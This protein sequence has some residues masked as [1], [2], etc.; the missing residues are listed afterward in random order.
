MAKFPVRPNLVGGQPVHG[1]R[2]FDRVSSVD[3]SHV[4]AV[5][6]SYGTVV[7]AAV[8]ARTAQPVWG[9]LRTAQRSEVQSYRDLAAKEVATVLTGG[10]AFDMPGVLAE[11]AYFA[12][13]IWTGLEQNARAVA[14]EA[15]RPVCHVAPFD[16]DDEA[17]AL[18]NDSV[19]GLAATLWASNVD[20]AHRVAQNLDVGLA[21][22][23]RWWLS[24]LRSPCGGN[25]RSDIGREGGRSSLEFCT[26]PTNV[27]IE[28][29][30]AEA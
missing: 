24:D 13:T 19:Y 30:H 14:E 18:A 29:D 15:S 20:G 9:R 23:N 28:F 17:V 22:V 11:G 21:R 3:H 8:A 25:G 2:T 16:T 7:D 6:E 5:C 26:R 12:P 10:H 27:C 1:A 4:V